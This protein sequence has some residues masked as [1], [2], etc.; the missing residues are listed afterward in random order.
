M[1]C[2]F[3]HGETPYEEFSRGD[4]YAAIVLREVTP[5]F[6]P[7][8]YYLRQKYTQWNPGACRWLCRAPL[9]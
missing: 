4:C 2:T 6:D 7:E 9:T 1:H 5:E 3:L 8:Q